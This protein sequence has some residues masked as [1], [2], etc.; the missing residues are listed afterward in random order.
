MP[1]FGF[2]KYFGVQT[3]SL[4]QF[5][6]GVGTSHQIGG[7]FGNAAACGTTESFNSFLGFLPGKG[8]KGAGQDEFHARERQ[9]LRFDGFFFELDSAGK[10]V[11]KVE[12][13]DLPGI[14]LLFVAGLQRLANGN[15]VVCNWGGHGRK[16]E[17]AQI[18]E[19]TRDKKV[20][21]R[22]FD[23]DK[24]GTISAAQVL[25]EKGNSA[26]GEILR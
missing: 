23:F 14:E 16:G 4:F 21:A 9:R 5:G 13:N 12:K 1:E 15:T 20:V 6:A 19:I 10:V 2:I 8:I 24:F 26:K 3:A 18:F 7:F 17:Q 11:W 25:D 22:M